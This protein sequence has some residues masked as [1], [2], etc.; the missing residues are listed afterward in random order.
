MVR[1]EWRIFRSPSWH[2]EPPAGF[3]KS[4]NLAEH[5]GRHRATK[6]LEVITQA[7]SDTAMPAW[8]PTLAT[9]ML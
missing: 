6:A 8:K 2:V 4:C 7:R 5:G 9:A 1:S 3:V